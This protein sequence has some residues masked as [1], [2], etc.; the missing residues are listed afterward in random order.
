VPAIFGANGPV[1]NPPTNFIWLRYA[2]LAFLA[3]RRQVRL[4]PGP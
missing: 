1:S 2:K 3:A 4:R